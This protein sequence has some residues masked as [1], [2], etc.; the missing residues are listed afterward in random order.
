MTFFVTRD[1]K[2]I[3]EHE[4]QGFHAKLLSGD[5]VTTDYYWVDGMEDWRPVSDYTMGMQTMKIDMTPA[6]PAS[7]APTAAA[8][9]GAAS[10]VAK[11]TSWLRKRR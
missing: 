5:I 11:L 1:G 7:P 6:A 2:Q 4:K 8:S 10:T 3:D 9:S